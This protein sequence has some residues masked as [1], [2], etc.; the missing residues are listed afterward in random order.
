MGLGPLPLWLTVEWSAGDML[1]GARPLHGLRPPQLS[2]A[3][4]P[5]SHELDDVLQ[6]FWT[7]TRP[8][9]RTGVGSPCRSRS[10]FVVGAAA[11]R[12]S[13]AAAQLAV[14][15]RFYDYHTSKWRSGSVLHNSTRNPAGLDS[16]ETVC[17][18]D[19]SCGGTTV[20]RHTVTLIYRRGKHHGNDVTTVSVTKT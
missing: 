4:S 14:R 5:S 17:T 20:G 6:R 10:S 7:V 1:R 19:Y 11:G 3:V 9:R 15:N 12:S 16:G 2:R 18:Q 8:T 13:V